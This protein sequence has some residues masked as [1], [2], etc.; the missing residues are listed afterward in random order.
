MA[1]KLDLAERASYV[2]S[3]T[4]NKDLDG[5][6]TKAATPDIEGG[7]LRSG[8]I[9]QLLSKESFGLLAQY[10]AVGLIY[11][12]RWDGDRQLS[13]LWLPPSSIHDALCIL[14]I[15]SIFSMITVWDVFRNQWF[16]LGGPIVENVPYAVQFI[17]GTFI[18]VELAGNGNEAAC[19]G[20]LTTVMNLS[21]PFAAT[22]TK[23]INGHF[24]V[25]NKDMMT[26]TH[27]VRTQVTYTILI[28]YACKL[29]AFSFLVLLPTQKAACQEL[30][31]N[32]GSSKMMGIFTISYCVFALVW[33]IMINLLSI[34]ES[35]KCLSI[36]G[37]CHN[38]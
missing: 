36:T 15:D 30:K 2:S 13:H 1:A 26:V 11:G 35:T 3:T 34:F 14:S 5:G 4:M 29:F 24:D 17:V 25:W 6:Y 28:S 38:N 19:Y 23:Q 18:V 21:Q 32:G 10:A 22:I 16:W 37:G 27:H 31:R 12:F 20:L 9:P 7:A 8:E 33:S